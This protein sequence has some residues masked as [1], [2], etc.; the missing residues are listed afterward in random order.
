MDRGE[1]GYSTWEDLRLREQARHASMV[2]T[3]EGL[4]AVHKEGSDMPAIRLLRELHCTDLQSFEGRQ[5]HKCVAG[6]AGDG[7]E[8]Q[9]P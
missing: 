3:T 5:V 1:K 7:I 9:V 4:P 8:V 2:R 6:Y